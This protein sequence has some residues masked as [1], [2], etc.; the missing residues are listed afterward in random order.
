[1]RAYLVRRLGLAVVTVVGASILI[2]A[3]MRVIPGDPVTAILARAELGLTPAEIA[4]M[5]EQFGLHLPLYQ[6][7]IQWVVGVVRLDPGTSIVRQIPVMTEFGRAL[8]V[9]AELTVLSLG[10]VVFI[11]IIV[12]TVTA[13]R[14]DTWWDYVFRVFTIGGLAVPVFWIG[15]LVILALLFWFNYTNPLVYIPFTQDP[16]TNLRQFLLPAFIG[17]FRSAAVCSRMIRSSML[18]ILNED[19][20]RTAYS[21]G[22]HEPV[23]I[24]RHAMK[25]A[26]VPVATIYGISLIG[27]FNGVVVVEIVFNLPG[28]GRL[29]VDSVAA[30]DYPNVQFVI[31]VS[32]VFASVIN[33]LVD[34]TYALLDPR[35]RVSA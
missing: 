32:V 7:Y 16:L 9:T 17:S 22:L 29:L 4:K 19:Y 21:K 11:S 5:R 35:V 10:F 2:F 25:N 12:G 26:F 6:Q 30:R 14:Q 24:L 13:I 8:P 27:L 18:D 15:I 1:M 20:I 33:L 23:V 31:L 3:I 28:L 34:L